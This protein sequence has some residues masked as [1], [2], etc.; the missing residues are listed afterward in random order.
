MALVDLTEL[1]NRIDW[2]LDDREKRLG[3]AALDDLSLDAI[4]YGRNWHPMNTPPRI[5]RL[6]L[7]AAMRYMNNYRG[8]VQSRAGDETEIYREHEDMGTA[9]FTSEEVKEIIS[10]ASGTRGKGFG[11]IPAYA[12]GTDPY[13]KMEY[14]P[15]PPGKWFPLYDPEDPFA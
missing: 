8:L 13:K 7:K 4:D 12:W 11:S 6:I 5:K 3:Q 14:V 2:D 15:A 1:E 9:A 10:I